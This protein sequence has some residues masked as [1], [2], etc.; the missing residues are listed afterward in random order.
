MQLTNVVGGTV[1]V[2][3]GVVATTVVGGAVVIVQLQADIHS[4][5]MICNKAHCASVTVRHITSYL[6]RLVSGRSSCT[7]AAVCIGLG[8]GST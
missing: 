7:T 2:G 6:L 3:G 4:V 5:M 8:A 1:V